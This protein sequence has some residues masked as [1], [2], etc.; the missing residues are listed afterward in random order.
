MIILCLHFEGIAK[1]LNYFVQQ[2]YYFTFP[3]AMHRD[4]EKSN[5]STPLSALGCDTV[6]LICIFLGSNEGIFSCAC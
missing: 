2:L 4:G 6:V 3:L 5:F 1:L